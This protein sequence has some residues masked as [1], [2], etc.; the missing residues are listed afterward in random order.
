MLSTEQLAQLQHVVQAHFTPDGRQLRLGTSDRRWRQ[1]RALA[2][3]AAVSA[4][5]ARV[6][7]LQ[8]ELAQAAE[9]Q[10][11]TDRAR[12]E[13]QQSLL[14]A[15]E[16]LRD[17]RL[18]LGEQERE[19]LA[20]IRELPPEGDGGLWALQRLADYASEAGHM[21]ALFNIRAAAHNLGWCID[22]SGTDEIAPTVGICPLCDC[23]STPRPPALPAPVSPSSQDPAGAGEGYSV[24][25]AGIARQMAK[26]ITYSGSRKPHTGK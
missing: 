8:K 23:D 21:A 5:L 22:S 20:L 17:A 16:K 6:S 3:P 11:A 13:K 10:L 18:E 19:K 14:E 25:S 4:L 7:S 24:P 12:F 26:E 2:T 15:Q 9:R 1:Y